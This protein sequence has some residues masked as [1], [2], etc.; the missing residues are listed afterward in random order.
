[1]VDVVLNMVIDL[2]AYEREQ[3]RNSLFFYFKKNSYL[4]PI[5][6]TGSASYAELHHV[7]H[8]PYSLG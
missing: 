1:M 3:L 2:D 8:S 5:F 4:F 7:E 6:I